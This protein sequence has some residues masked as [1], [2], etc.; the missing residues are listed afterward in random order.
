MDFFYICLWDACKKVLALYF[1]CNFP[2][3]DM[4]LLSTAD[5]LLNTN[6]QTT[7]GLCSFGECTIASMHVKFC[8]LSESSE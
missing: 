6:T 1:L 5:W 4:T 2:S 3:G 7:A 8:K